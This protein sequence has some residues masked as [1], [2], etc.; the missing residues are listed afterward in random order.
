MHPYNC[1]D[2]DEEEYTNV[3]IFGSILLLVEVTPVGIRNDVT[4]AREEDED[5]VDCEV[6][7]SDDI[8]LLFSY[9]NVIRDMSFGDSD[10]T[11]TD[12]CV[13]ST[14]CSLR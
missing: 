6:G 7:T 4:W 12:G 1:D 8:I 11:D 5:D 13:V 10:D 9:R 14:L 2:D 3:Y